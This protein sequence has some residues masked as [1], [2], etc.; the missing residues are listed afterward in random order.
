MRPGSYHLWLLP[1]LLLLCA[2]AGCE[3]RSSQRYQ[4]V[5]AQARMF[6]NGAAIA[7]MMLE[8]SKI[9]LLDSVTGRVWE[10]KLSSTVFT[11][12]TPSELR[13]QK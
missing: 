3:S 4:I 11:E 9:Y 2:T 8:P 5:Y 13:A 7:Q 6:P 1:L 12:I 10:T